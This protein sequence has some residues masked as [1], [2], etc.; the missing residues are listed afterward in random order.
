MVLIGAAIGLILAAAAG[1]L[2]VTFLFGVPPLD[3]VVFSGAAALFAV[4][5]FA[6][7]YIPSRRATRIDPMLALRNE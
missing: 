5:G 7:C 1:R 6:A 4:I 2:L 3:F